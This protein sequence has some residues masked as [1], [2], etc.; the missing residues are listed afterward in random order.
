VAVNEALASSEPCKRLVSETPCAV[1]CGEDSAIADF[2]SLGAVG[3]IGVVNNLVPE[4]I[5]DLVRDAGPGT[6]SVRAAATVEK[7]RPLIRD[8]FIESNPVPVKTALA[9]MLPSV[10]D[11]VRLPLVPL[12]DQNRRQLRET[13]SRCGLL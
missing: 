11:E 4:L 3:V 9:M 12:T 7:L 5:A 8:L 6:G 1:L 2:V 10:S 13:M